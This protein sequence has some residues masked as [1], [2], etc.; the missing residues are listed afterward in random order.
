MCFHPRL[1]PALLFDLAL[2]RACAVCGAPLSPGMASPP[3]CRGCEGDLVPIAGRRCRTC[4][5]TILSEEGTCMDCRER[6]HV[7][8]EAVPLFDFEGPFRRL[9]SA[10]KFEDRRSL[11]PFLAGLAAREIEA[12]WPGWPIVPVPPRPGKM[13]ERGW[14]QV[15][16]IAVILG[17][18]GFAVQRLLER[19]PSAQQKRLGRA[20]RGMNARAA[21]R[22]KQDVAVPEAALLVDDIM[23]TG[24]TADACAAALK[25]AGARRVA[26][27]VLALD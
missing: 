17:A 7:F 13:R 25:D 22:L 10:Y 11:A 20:D 27:L 15:E 23:T 6:R 4:G 24:A 16:D 21:Y 26:L 5:A 19:L 8:D 14:D 9:L 3:L 2:P 12:R 18:R 1:A